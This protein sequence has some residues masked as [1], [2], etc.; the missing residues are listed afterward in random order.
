MPT[1]YTIGLKSGNQTFTVDLA[2]VPLRV[3]LI[4]RNSELA[5]GWFMDIEHRGGEFALRGL[6]VYL[7]QNILLQH[8]HLGLGCFWLEM[9]NGA[10]PRRLAYESIGPNA[11]LCWTDDPEYL[12]NL[13][14]AAKVTEA[15]APITSDFATNGMAYQS[16][17]KWLDCGQFG[18]GKGVEVVKDRTSGWSATIVIKGRVQ[19]ALVAVEDMGVWGSTDDVAAR[20]L[21]ALQTPASY[22]SELSA[23]ATISYL[24]SRLLE[25]RDF[26]TWRP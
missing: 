7:D 8:G 23:D 12:R 10:N 3:S 6:P 4:W 13:L 25:K 19:S 22:N 15:P 5:P 26:G 11:V 16:A 20:V 14:K 2:G 18:D 17:V 21:E 24:T 9:L 1:V